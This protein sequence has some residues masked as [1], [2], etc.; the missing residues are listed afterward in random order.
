M[1]CDEIH[2]EITQ[3]WVVAR[4]KFTQHGT[5]SGILSVDFEKHVYD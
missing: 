1:E 2:H 5:C 3:S 4:E